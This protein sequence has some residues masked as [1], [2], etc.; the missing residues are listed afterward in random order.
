[1][2]EETTAPIL[3]ALEQRQDLCS[4]CNTETTFRRRGAGAWFCTSC[5]THQGPTDQQAIDDRARVQD[6]IHPAD[7]DAG[8]LSSLDPIGA[9]VG[10]GQDHAAGATES[11]EG[12][13]GAGTGILDRHTEGVSEVTSGS[14]SVYLERRMR[15][16]TK[17]LAIASV[18]AICVLIVAALEAREHQLT[19]AAHAHATATA[20]LQAELRQTAQAVRT[21]TAVAHQSATAA[22]Q[23]TAAAQATAAAEAQQTAHVIRVGT[24][25]ARTTTTAVAQATHAAVAQATLLAQTRSTAVAEAIAATQAQASAQATAAVRAT[26]DAQATKIA[27]RP[28][29]VC[30]QQD[31]D[32]P[33]ALCTQSDDTIG[34]DDWSGARLSY[35]APGDDF[36]STSTHFAVSQRDDDGSY[37]ELGTADTSTSLSSSVESLNLAWVFAST[38]VYPVEGATYQVE[39]DNG[40]ILLGTAE[41]TYAD[42]STSTE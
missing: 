40:S 27:M 28:V 3:N 8:E 19:T 22:A 4:V 15:K 1:M 35:M 13:R 33:D 26:A 12:L 11:A 10:H 6:S 17:L 37:S 7:G 34:A 30:S 24:A 42:Q 29:R 20:V 9:A 23:Q 38:G 41:F 2:S 36:T 16:R 21:A 39:V 25:I 14:G 18:A 5:G 31:Y 32:G